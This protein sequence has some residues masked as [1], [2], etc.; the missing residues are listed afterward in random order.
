MF[1]HIENAQQAQEAVNYCHYI[2]LGQRG[3]NSTRLNRYGIDDL[4]SFVQHAANETVVIA[5][6]ESLEGLEQLDEIL[7]VEGINIILEGAADLSHSMGMPWQTNHPK[8]QEKI[9]E[10]YTKTRN[11]QKNFCAI[12]RKP[13]DISTWKQQSVQFFVLGDDR[14]IIRRAPQNHLNI[15]KDIS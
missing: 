13:E 9:Q 5:M 7:K 12:P 14:S 6:I 3:L 2:P 10:M 15:F 4:A 1:P 11:S 8:V